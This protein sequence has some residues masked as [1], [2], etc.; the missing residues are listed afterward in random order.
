VAPREEENKYVRT[1]P[2]GRYIAKE[3]IFKDHIV[4]MESDWE[5]IAYLS[6]YFPL[7]ESQRTRS[8]SLAISRFPSMVVGIT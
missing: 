1:N 6:R 2:I 8:D 7:W 5:D 3:T 4:Q